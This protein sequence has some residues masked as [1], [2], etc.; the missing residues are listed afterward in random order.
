MQIADTADIFGG[1]FKLSAR[2]YFP[3]FPDAFVFIPF[4]YVPIN[5]YPNERISEYMSEND[6]NIPHEQWFFGKFLGFR[7]N[8]IST[9]NK[10]S[11]I[12][13]EIYYGHFSYTEK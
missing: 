5:C 13:F 9:R 4:K 1:L 7:K 12:I 3:P 2:G 8:I 6:G 10:F 11:N